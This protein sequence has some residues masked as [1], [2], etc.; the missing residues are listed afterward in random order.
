[1]HLRI[2]KYLMKHLLSLLIIVFI[3]CSL[4]MAQEISEKIDTPD[5]DTSQMQEDLQYITE[6]INQSKQRISLLKK[7]FYSLYPTKPFLIVN[8]SENEFRLMQGKEILKQNRC[9][10]GSYVLLRAEGY[11]E[12]LFTTPRGRFRVTVKLKNPWW[13]KPDWAFIEEGIPIPS[14]ESP[15]RYQPNVLGDFALGFGNGYLVHGTIYKRLL[16]L[17]VTHGCVRLDD[18]D[19][20]LVFNTMT[21]GSKIYIY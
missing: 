16:G 1:M 19:M 21:H 3:L 17:P 13:Y 20:R 9:S 2:F 5:L 12:W 6:K 11:R 10:T 8:T 14:K 4:G 15:K 18:E 7:Q